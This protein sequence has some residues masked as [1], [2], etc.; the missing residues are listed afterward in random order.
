[1][2]NNFVADVTHFPPCNKWTI[3][4]CTGAYFVA[5]FANYLKTAA[6]SPDQ[7]AILQE[8]LKTVLAVF[9]SKIYTFIKNVA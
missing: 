2:V 7:T 4:L 8:I 6:D 3:C 5:C 9:F 1:M